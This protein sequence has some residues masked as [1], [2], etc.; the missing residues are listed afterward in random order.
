VS[1]EL[2]VVGGTQ[3]L[4]R[5][6]VD[7]AIRRGYSVTTFN[8]GVTGA[9]DPRVTSLRG[10]RTDPSAWDAIVERAPYDVVVDTCGYTPRDVLASATAL[11]P[12]VGR[13]VFVSSI[14]AHPEPYREP[15]SAETPVSECPLDAGPDHGDYGIRKAGCET[16]LTTVLAGR[17]VV[18]RPGLILGPQESI[19]RL[20]WWLARMA[21]GG[22]VLAPG[23]PTHPFQA[24][25]A[26]DLAAFCLSV[27]E[28]DD[29]GPFDVVSPPGRDSWG[30]LLSLAV[31]ST[32]A[33]A[34]LRWVDDQTSLD[35]GVEPWSELPMW[36]PPDPDFA[37]FLDVRPDRAEA[38]GL[39]C[40]PLAETVSDTW[41]WQQT[42]TEPFRLAEGHGMSPEKEASVLATL[43]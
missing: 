28:A 14:S 11:A 31:A 43:G 22:E 9:D 18:V 38:A 20:P 19:G 33:G 3:F 32:D 37:H 21:R 2:L 41:A 39:R 42:L 16:A 8:R 10:D 27:G 15:M 30:D 5:H 6:V 34:T 40:R 7:E 26:R 17:A 35:A 23:S 25:D 36:L 1:P 12:V 4:G 29:A 24:V 13:Y